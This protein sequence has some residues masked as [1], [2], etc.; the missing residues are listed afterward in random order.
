M[1]PMIVT[2]VLLLAGAL[3]RAASAHAGAAVAY[4]PVR[5]GI[6]VDGDLGDWPAATAWQ[7]ILHHGQAYGPT[8][9]DKADLTT[10]AD[11]SPSFAAGWDPVEGLIYVAVRVR[12][13]TVAVSAED[14]QSTDACEV[15]VEGPHLGQQLPSWSTASDSPGLVYVMW[16]PGGSYG[17][18]LN[19][20][21]IT[22]NPNLMGGDITGTKTRGAY[23]RRGDVSIYEWA[24]EAYDHYPDQATKLELGKTVGFEIFVA[25]KDRPADHA[26]ILTW[27]AFGTNKRQNT[28]LLGNLVLIQSGADLGALV[29]TA[30]DKKE[31][32]PLAGL[33]LGAWQD[34]TAAGGARSDAAGKARIQL[35]PGTYTVRL[36]RGQ[37]YQPAETAAVTV[38][39]GGETE[40]QLAA[41]PIEVPQVLK[42]AAAVYQG[43]QA[44]RDTTATEVHMVRAGMDNRMGMPMA[45][46]LA[47][48][49]RLRLEGGMGPGME[50]VL[51]SDGESLVTYMAMVQQYTQTRAPDTLSVA[52]LQ[53]GMQGP[54]GVSLV[55]QLL[56]SGDPLQEILKGVEEVRPL[57]DEKWNGAPVSV[58]VL[59]RSAAAMASPMMPPGAAAD[60]T[61]DVRVWIGKKDFLVRQVAYDLDMSAIAAS[62][63]EAQRA[64]LAGMRTE[65]TERHTAIEVDPVLPPQTFAF[66]PPAKASLVEQFGPPGAASD[67]SELVGK[68]APDFT[69]PGIGGG[70][71]RL[72]DF[73]GQV[74]I[75][76]FW[77]TWCGPCKAEMPTF[78]ALH[79]QYQSQGF[80]V[81]GVVVDD[82]AAKV[83][84]YAT[85]NG[86]DF[87]LATADAA[88][89]AA[90]GNISAI[91][92]TVIIDR[93]GVVRYAHMGVPEDQLVYQ[94]L[95]EE[96]LGE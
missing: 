58:L 10:S 19:S 3:P 56:M 87:P 92:V 13:D 28:Q 65:I 64:M 85:A 43:L 60:A 95:V 40:V 27:A 35:L 4:A 25:D 51:V 96:L 74:V 31:R 34:S 93:K 75:V 11:L 77:A 12:D 66:T 46:A 70:Q 6:Q 90:Y 61:I 23:A 83:R 8:D 9:I 37:G 71:V 29:V 59:R 26:A 32:K 76:D 62:L 94:K 54:G 48:P 7:P 39:A 45:F 33:E 53:P 81:I 52:A 2:L 41:A 78:V 91:P 88:V 72:A 16:P 38:T 84:T 15:I 42:R 69:L 30:I 17:P 63:P 20:P 21:D 82:T 57:P 89:K 80:S 73:A 1:R 68:P 67:K 36:Q 49:N 50:T 86:I 47:R 22:A 5:T 24:L 79:R 14:F 55:L 44:Y 18:G